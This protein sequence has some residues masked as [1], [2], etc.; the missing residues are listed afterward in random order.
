MEW[1]RLQVSDKEFV[2]SKSSL[3]K[4]P[5]FNKL[6]SN[7]NKDTDVIRIDGDPRIFRHFLNCLIM[8]VYHIPDKYYKNVQSLLEFYG[9]ESSIVPKTMADP[10]EVQGQSVVHYNGTEFEHKFVG[11][12]RDI[13]IVSYKIKPFFLLKILFN[14][15]ILL[16]Y[17]GNGDDSSFFDCFPIEDGETRPQFAKLKLKFKDDAIP[18]IEKLD[19]KFSILLKSQ[20]QHPIS[21]DMSLSYYHGK[22]VVL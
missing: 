3:Y 21:H 6:L 11:K 19:G 12:L 17:Y 7:W 1:Y 18:N 13:E 16:H 5:Y 15:N 22:V 9:V 4:S 2:I 14:N 20:M 8:D 10:I